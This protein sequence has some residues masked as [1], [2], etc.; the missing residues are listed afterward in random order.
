[1]IMKK[2]KKDPRK[3]RDTSCLCIRGLSIVKMLILLKSIYR[4]NIVSN[5]KKIVDTDKLILKFTWEVTGLRTSQTILKRTM[6]K[7]EP[8][9][10]IVSTTT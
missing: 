7:G 4:I 1:M 3:L 2:C 10:Q 9:C 5:K 8:C 6:K